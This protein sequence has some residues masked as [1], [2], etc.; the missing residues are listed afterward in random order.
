[1]PVSPQDYALWSDLT[2]NP[3]PQTP[4]E[5]M[6]LAPEVYSFTRDVNQGR[7][8]PGA[9]RR[10]VDVIGKTALAAGAIAGGVYLAK[11][12]GTLEL[13]DEPHIGTPPQPQGV[14]P[15]TVT[16]VTPPTTS[17]RYGQYVLPHQTAVMGLLRG[18]SPGKPTV[19]DSEE[20]PAT[21]SHV[22]STSQSFGPGSEIEQLATSAVPHSPVRDRA[23]DLIAEYLG[24]IAAEQRDQIKIDKS[25]DIHNAG[26]QGKMAPYIKQLHKE[27]RAEGISP[28]GGS[29]VAAAERFRGTPAYTAMMQA[30]GA[31]MDPEELVG[32]PGTTP[33]FTEVRATPQTRIAAP[34]PTPTPTPA[35]APVRE[36]VTATVPA[37]F[38]TPPSRSAEG[39]ELEN[40]SRLSGVP[41]EV[42][43]QAA[44]KTQA[45]G[46]IVTTQPDTIRVSKPAKVRANEFLSA[47]SQ[48][49]GPLATYAISPERS[50]AVSGMAFYPGGELGVEMKSRG[51]PVEYAYATTDPY[52]LAMRD[53]ADEGFPDEMG[54]IAGI[55]AN[56]AL[57]HQMGLQ[58]AVERGGTIREKRQPIY[59]GL[60]SDADIA[61]A[62][63][64]KNAR[65]RAQAEYHFETRQI[66]DALEQR[67]NARRAG[68][69]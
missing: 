30:A 9:I 25:I 44:L 64:G 42:L 18:T 3:Y 61:S 10:A 53:Y 4:A 65:A 36:V 1:M 46:E 52:R 33:V 37:A 11:N 2:G 34:A 68:L 26:I 45:P 31:S 38:S 35:P 8:P 17:D 49:Q 20:K 40:L 69:L 21:Q 55:A 57:A 59:S 60:M 43:R 24:G 41:V 51:K 47:M 7:R 63:M 15:V 28:V 6:A 54:S 56:N 23:D 5:R 67:A 22:I 13:D 27:G 66:M 48:D 32:A 62:G 39:A 29:S 12:F 16:D 19:V 58:R 14:V 50:K